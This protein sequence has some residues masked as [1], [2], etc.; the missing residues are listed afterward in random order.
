M[1][2]FN[3]F[4]DRVYEVHRALGIPEDY[5]ASC[6]LPLCEE[7]LELVVTEPDYYGRQQQLIPPAFAAWSVMRSAAADDGVV[8][9]IIS[10]FRSLN[11]QR[12]LIERKLERGQTISAILAVNAAPGFS[13]HHTG[14]AVD[15]GTTG[16]D[17]L[18]EAFELTEAFDWLQSR[19]KE[20]GFSLSYPRDN[21]FGISYEPWHWCFQ[22][23]GSG[24]AS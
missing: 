5:A 17:A 7:P 6:G 2:D 1:A 4:R 21:P 12:Q 11:Y 9:H 19:A 22:N 15:I 10:A 23:S 16:C 3:T 18:V 8:I 13:E 20:F 24:A 14:R